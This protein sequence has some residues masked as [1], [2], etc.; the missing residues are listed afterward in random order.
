MKQTVTAKLQLQVSDEQKELLHSTMKAY[1]DACSYVAE[2]VFQTRD[3]TASH[4]QKDKYY[5][6]RSRFGLRAQMA[7]SC[8]RTVI[9]AYETIRTNQRKWIM[10]RF[11]A[12]QLDLV[13]NRDYSLNSKRDLFSVNTLGGRIKVPFYRGGME[14]YFAEGFEFGTAKLVYKHGKF[15]LHIPVTCE[16]EELRQEDV[17]NIVGVDRGI[18]FLVTTYDSHGKTEFYDGRAVKQKR[19]HYKL[20]RS[21]LQKVGTPSSRRRLKAIGQRENRWMHDVN[22]CISKAL[23]EK[24]DAKNKNTMAGTMFVLEDLSGIRSATER[25]RVQDRYVSVSWA[26]YDLEQ[27]LTY[28]ALRNHQLVVK[29]D[30]AYTSQTCPK[31]GHTEKANRDKKNH[32]FRCRSCG[33]SSNDDRIGAMNLHRMG[34]NLSST[35]CSC[36]GVYSPAQ[37]PVNVP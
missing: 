29:V 20:L 8:I 19:A 37:V 18:R 22:H 21:E 7:Q 17:S 26:Y 4:I 23:T 9:A 10:P 5:E 2:H 30:P 32:L 28:K 14:R 11:R 36:L 35:G 1:A 31:C 24:L 3:L 15:F 16:F 12:P 25:V 34:M 27:K 33:Y 6:I 13:W